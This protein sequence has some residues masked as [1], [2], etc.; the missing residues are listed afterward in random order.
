MRSRDDSFAFYISEQHSAYLDHTCPKF[1]DRVPRGGPYNKDQTMYIGV[2][3]GLH[4][5]N[6]G[7]STSKELYTPGKFNEQPRFHD[8]WSSMR[9][10]GQ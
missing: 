5:P 6:N 9:I 10:Q 1:W 2:Y 8:S 3:D 7:I 4:Q